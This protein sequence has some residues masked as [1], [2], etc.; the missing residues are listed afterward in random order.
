M[1]RE[2]TMKAEWIR[3]GTSHDIQ[4]VRRLIAKYVEHTNTFASTLPTDT[5]PRRTNLLAKK[6]HLCRPRPKT[7]P[8]QATTKN[9]TPKPTRPLHNKSTRFYRWTLIQHPSVIAD[10][11]QKQIASQFLHANLYL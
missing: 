8:D 2:V 1:A 5:S 10:I 7:R 9:Q 6:C 4:Q 3:S 11:G